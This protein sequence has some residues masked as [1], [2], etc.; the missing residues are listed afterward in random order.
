MKY[1]ALVFSA[2]I[3]SITQAQKNNQATE[4]F[5]I[6]GHVKSSVTFSL[7]DAGSFARHFIDSLVIYNH[8]QERKHVIRS[9]R[10]E[11][12]YREQNPDHYGGGWAKSREFKRSYCYFITTG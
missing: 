11:Y 9:I 2:F 1:L 12:W 3:V 7:S 4:K 5:I 6:D 10:G 8:L